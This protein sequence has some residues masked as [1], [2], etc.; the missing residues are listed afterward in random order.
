MPFSMN[1]SKES[2][3][4]AAPLEEGWYVLMFKS[5]SPKLAGQNKDSV[6]LNAQYEIVNNA[7][8]ELNGR[9]VFD[10][11]NLKGAWVIQDFVHSTGI[12]MEPVLGPSGE[13][14]TYT[15]PG[16]FKGMDT[17]PDDPTKW[18]YLGPLTNKVF[19]AEIA[20]SEYNGKKSNKIRQYKCGVAGCTERHSTNLLR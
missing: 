8:S 11:L 17:D 15:I 1:F 19:E 18:E 16:V 13:V 20:I 14:E 2:L 7:N 6:S 9:K 12:E 4:G 10:N 3:S 5:F